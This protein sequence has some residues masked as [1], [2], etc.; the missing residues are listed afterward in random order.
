MKKF[1]DGNMTLNIRDLKKLGREGGAVAFL[2]GGECMILKPKYGTITKRAFVAGEVMY[3]NLRVD[4]K[5]IY[6]SIKMI[7]RNGILIAKKR[8]YGNSYSL[9]LTGSGY[10]RN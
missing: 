4:Y 3:V 5:K 2:E 10:H 6:S 9:K 8:K 1:V 7:N